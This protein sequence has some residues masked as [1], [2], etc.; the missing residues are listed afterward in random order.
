MSNDGVKCGWCGKF[1]SLVLGPPVHYRRDVATSFL[2]PADPYPICQKCHEKDAAER[3]AAQN[4][5]I[6]MSEIKGDRDE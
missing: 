6:A 5:A 3:F 1:M 4:R 2:E